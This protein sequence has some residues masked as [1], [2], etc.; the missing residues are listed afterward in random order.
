MIGLK[1]SVPSLE[2]NKILPLVLCILANTCFFLSRSA[3]EA[4]PSAICVCL[5]ACRRSKQ[6]DLVFKSFLGARQCKLC[7]CVC[8]GGG[9]GKKI[10]GEER[11]K[12]G[13]S[14]GAQGLLGDSRV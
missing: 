6:K 10:R 1:L 7:V 9:A 14:G 11:R 4:R 2:K 13:E 3:V 12:N 8:L 5:P